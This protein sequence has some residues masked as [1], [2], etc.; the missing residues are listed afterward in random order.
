MTEVVLPN[1]TN[2]MGILQGGRIIQ[3]M[4]IA[5][6]IVA[7]THSE[8]VC[9]TAAVDQVVFKNPAHTG[10]I[11]LIKARITRAFNTSMEIYVEA[12]ARKVTSKDE[13]MIN[14]AWF[15][16]VAIAENS[17]AT[18]V[19]EVQPQS[20]FEISLFEGALK[21]RQQRLATP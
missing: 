19:P 8:C 16:F 6:A 11:V 17:K 3:W 12:W 5:S 18:N 15:T 9:V 21:R 20:E 13:K 14:A 7:Q 1:D 10:D 4:D 2:P